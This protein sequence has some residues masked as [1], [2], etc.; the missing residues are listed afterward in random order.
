MSRDRR[1]LLDLQSLTA[2]EITGKLITHEFVIRKIT[3]EG[4]DH[5][6]TIAV[7]LWNGIVGVVAGR[8]GVANHV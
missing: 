7:H 1:H 3:V 6:V 8:I 5:P 4:A 2:A